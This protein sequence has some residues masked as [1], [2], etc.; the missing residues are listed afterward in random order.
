MSETPPSLGWPHLLMFVPGVGAAATLV[1]A[2]GRQDPAEKAELMQA[3][4]WQGGA[5]GILLVHGM[6]QAAIW[7]MVWLIGSMPVELVGQSRSFQYMPMVLGLCTHAN[8][9]AGAAEWLILAWF[10]LKAS[11]GAPYPARG[12][13]KS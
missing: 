12:K 5:L 6:L 11:R 10:A 4:Q 3:A 8:V 2:S 9:L 1:M 7:F 13:D